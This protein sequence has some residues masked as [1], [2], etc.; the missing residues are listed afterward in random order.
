LIIDRYL[1]REISKPLLAIS[2]ILIIIF[3]GASTAQF[4]ADANSGMLWISEV[5][6][7]ILLRNLISL[8][9]M[10]PIALYLG[11]VGGLGRLY[12]DSEITALHAAG[13]SEGRLVWP[14]LGLSLLCALLVG[15]LSLV[16]RPGAYKESY[17]I[18][19]EAAI[20]FNLDD[21]EAGRF[22]QLD[23]SRTIFVDRIDR[24]T[25]QVEGVFL[26]DA[27]E[28]RTQVTYADKAYQQHNPADTQ[29][30]WVFLHG[31]T[32]EIDKK[33]SQDLVITYNQMVMRLDIGKLS[34]DYKRKAASSLTLASSSNSGD[35][36]ELQWRLS[37]PVAT[38]LLGL[39]GVPM[40]RA[41][42][43]Q[44][45]YV[46]VLLAIVVFIIYYYLSAM[47]MTWVDKGRVGAFP[48]LWWVDTLMVVLIALLLVQ[49]TWRFRLK[50]PSI[51]PGTGQQ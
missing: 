2:L 36:A 11:I 20:R 10:L 8:E 40:S 30:A 23:A 1:I 34:Q 43:R 9:L 45:K 22:Y 24:D 4:L 42:P 51:P 27:K 18:Q 47:A 3:V 12:T 29:P 44:G 46:K 31:H 35:I 13:M 15:F 38:I 50:S 25:G 41:T 39:L 48:G 49:Q 14:V 19:A 28:D 6:K 21:V 33:G 16:A 5:V 37:R 17:Q 26:T 32:Y 7:L